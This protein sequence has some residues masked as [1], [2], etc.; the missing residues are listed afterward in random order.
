MYVIRPSFGDCPMKPPDGGKTLPAD[1]F[2]AS[3]TN[4][5]WL[6]RDKLRKLIENE[7]GRF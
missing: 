1:F 4:E 6:S 5:Q 3:D 2:Y 7:M